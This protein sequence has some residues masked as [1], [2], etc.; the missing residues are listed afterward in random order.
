MPSRRSYT[1]QATMSGWAEAT[2]RLPVWDPHPGPIRLAPYQKE[3][4]D[5]ARSGKVRQLTLMCASQMGKTLMMLIMLGYRIDARPANIMVIQPREA[6]TKRFLHNKL[7]PF[8]AST[9]KIAAKMAVK[10]KVKTGT[11]NLQTIDYAGGYIVF[12][13]SGSPASMR[14]ETNNVCLADEVDVYEG[15]L[16]ASNPLDVIR[17]RL[18]QYVR[19]GKMFVLSTPTAA[20]ASLIESEYK[21]G[22]GSRW[23][24]TCDCGV[25]Y[26]Q[27]WDDHVRIV[28][29]VEGI[30]SATLHCPNGCLIDEEQRIRMIMTGRFIPAR[31]HITDHRSFHLSQLDSIHVPFEE[32]AANGLRTR[33]KGRGFRTQCLAEPYSIEALEPLT[34][35]GLSHLLVNEYSLE[36]PWIRTCGVDVQA[37]RI[38]YQIVDW[39]KQDHAFVQLHQQIAIPPDLE[40]GVTKA[41]EILAPVLLEN[42]VDMTF[43]DSGYRP[44]AV[45]RGIRDGLKPLLQRPLTFYVGEEWKDEQVARVKPVRGHTASSFDKHLIMSESKGTTVLAVDEAKMVVLDLIDLDSIRVNRAGVPADF[46]RQFTS[47]NLT[48]QEKA[49]GSMERSWVLRHKGARNEVLD[50]FV[51]ALCANRLFENT[52]Q[53]SRSAIVR[54]LLAQAA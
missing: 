9:P 52:R 28:E 32:T 17:Q 6:D 51:Y 31:P 54:E 18:V 11:H 48:V 7:E 23:H 41:M 36:A 43:V 40:V 2:I 44:D 10:G 12:A 14:G 47:E 30:L 16:D 19:R 33:G 15:N 13:N 20:G 25:E 39:D 21:L 42:K 45:S 8:L 50:C 46:L 4:L 1:D 27:R 24:I 29:E 37:N 38:E 3:I 34:E 49:N 5:A 26:A 22:D 35:E 53:Y